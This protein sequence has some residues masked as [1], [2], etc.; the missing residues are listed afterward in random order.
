[1]IAFSSKPQ[2]QKMQCQKLHILRKRSTLFTPAS[3][4]ST[5]GSKLP[6]PW[7]DV[8]WSAP[9]QSCFPEVVCCPSHR[10]RGR[11]GILDDLL[12]MLQMLQWL[13]DPKD[14]LVTFG[15]GWYPSWGD[16]AMVSPDHFSIYPG[17]RVLW[18]RRQRFKLLFRLLLPGMA[19]A[20]LFFGG[21][22]HGFPAPETGLPPAQRG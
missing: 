8:E 18:L 22:Q 1:M 19:R 15:I 2:G 3:N 9:S 5:R 7:F 6:W 21:F 17:P 13:M 11:N 20:S 10:L 12:R 16:W 14:W 4:P